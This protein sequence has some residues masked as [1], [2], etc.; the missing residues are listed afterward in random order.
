MPVKVAHRRSKNG[1]MTRMVNLTAD[2]AY[3][4]NLLAKQLG[5]AVADV[6]SPMIRQRLRA[7]LKRHEIDPDASWKR[8]E[9]SE[10][11]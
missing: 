6:L 7:T 4:A 5:V 9:S 2:E 1:R 10:R 8:F 11:N 3:W